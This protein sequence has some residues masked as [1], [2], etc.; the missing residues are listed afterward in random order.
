MTDVRNSLRRREL[1]LLDRRKK[2]ER[3]KE[4]EMMKEKKNQRKRQKLSSL[5]SSYL[6]RNA[7]SLL[8]FYINE[9]SLIKRWRRRAVC[10][11]EKGRSLV[12]IEIEPR[13][14]SFLQAN[15]LSSSAHL[16]GKREVQKKER[17]KREVDSMDLNEERRENTPD[18]DNNEETQI[19]QE[20][21]KERKEDASRIKTSQ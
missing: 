14:P 19:K 12:C 16:S 11:P 20:R 10:T 21:R 9:L 3:R 15:V 4:R 8:S 17:K 2:R 5:L 13:W 6:W 7:R 18:S 1:F